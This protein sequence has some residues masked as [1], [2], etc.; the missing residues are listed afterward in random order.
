MFILV[1]VLLIFDLLILSTAV[2][3]EDIRGISTLDVPTKDVFASPSEGTDITKSID[4]LLTCHNQIEC[5]KP[6][7]QLDKKIRIYLCKQVAPNEKIRYGIRFHYLIKEGLSR[8]PNVELVGDKSHAEIIFYL[9]YSSVWSKSECNNIADKFR[10]V[11]LDEQD[12]SQKLFNVPNDRNNG[13]WLGYFKRS[14]AERSN[15]KSTGYF[16]SFSNNPQILPIT[17]SLSEK[18]VKPVFNSYENRT[19][20]F[21][22]TL[23]GSS[24][25]DPARLRVK[26]WTAEYGAKRSVMNYVA[27]EINKSTRDKIDGDYFSTLYSS[28]I[29]VTTNPS[30]YEG[31]IRFMESMASGSLVFVDRTLTPVPHPFID[32]V[33]VVYYDNDNK[34]DLFAKLDYYRNNV[35]EAKKIAI[36]G[37][38]NAMKYH[39]TVAVMDYVLRTVH[40]KLDPNHVHN[41]TNT[42]VDMRDVAVARSKLFKRKRRLLI[43]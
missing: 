40:V 20:E 41:Y 10:T 38:L 9:P 29:I 34:T 28:K 15:G 23:R 33:H 32:K 18:Y 12:S 30:A 42:G 13:T 8:H 11:V 39:R 22:C 5:I 14:Y 26:T 36:N 2:S 24:N 7:L 16:P 6:Q 4:E 43:F 27:G 35:D 1:A 17:Y 21:A 19:L 3:K 25:K 31:D 37:Y